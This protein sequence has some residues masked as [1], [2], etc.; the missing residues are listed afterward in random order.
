MLHAIVDKARSSLS[1]WGPSEV[2]IRT[3]I[4]QHLADGLQLFPEED[5]EFLLHHFVGKASIEIADAE[6][7]LSGNVS[8]QEVLALVVEH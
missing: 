3:L 1:L 6:P 5:L 8:A 7:A 2:H 4:T